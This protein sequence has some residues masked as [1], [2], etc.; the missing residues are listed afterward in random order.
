MVM[1]G[2][3]KGWWL[4][5]LTVTLLA[6]CATDPATQ[7]E[8]MPVATPR[9]PSLQD[10]VAAVRIGQFL[11]GAE[12]DEAELALLFYQRG[13]YFSRMGL[14]WLAH[15]DFRRAVEL[16]PDFAEAYNQLGVQFTLM[17]QFDDAYEALDSAIELAPNAD[18]PLLNRGIA[19]HYAG[20]HQLALS[21][22]ENYY[23]RDVSDPYRVIWLYLIQREV[24]AQAARDR[25]DHLLPLVRQGWGRALLAYF[26][27]ELSASELLRQAAEAEHENQEGDPADRDERLCEAYFYIG[28]QLLAE[29]NN[30]AAAN[31]FR[32]AAGTNIF[33]FVEHNFALYELQQLA[34]AGNG[35]SNGPA[36]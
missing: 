33:E 4:A 10:Q 30:A 22:L 12:R 29:G 2:M 13:L 20:R 14:D 27:G 19:L 24:D 35:D 23:R 7:F 5:L 15:V 34:G 11:D 36:S 28:Q 16:R 26:S 3:A 18:F 17:G 32:L 31:Y 1:A 25:L 9:Q 8:R 21:D 6:G